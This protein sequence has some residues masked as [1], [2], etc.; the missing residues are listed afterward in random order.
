[1]I[2]GPLIGFGFGYGARTL[3]VGPLNASLIGLGVT[4]VYNLGGFAAIGAGATWVAK[5]LAAG[6][7]A[8]AG[9]STIAAATGAVLITGA[10]GYTAATV[11]S[12]ETGREQLTDFLTGKVSPTEYRRALDAAHNRNRSLA[13]EGNVAGIP[14]G[15]SEWEMLNP[16]SRFNPFTGQ[17][18]P[19]YDPESSMVPW[20]AR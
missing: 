4:A 5:D 12:G 3:G 8:A 15:T 1:M 11:I 6:A 13:V 7:A 20:Y 19:L 10:V 17:E 9:V 2:V 14:A 18:N 16:Q